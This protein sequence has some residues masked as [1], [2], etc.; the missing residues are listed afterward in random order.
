[1]GTY[2]DSEE[3]GTTWWYEIKARTVFAFKCSAFGHKERMKSMR[4]KS[5]SCSFVSG[6]ET[7]A[8]TDEGDTSASA[9]RTDRILAKRNSYHIHYP[10]W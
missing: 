9:S 1:M 8:D 10:G 4:I 2:S 7:G 6:S 5:R 3:L